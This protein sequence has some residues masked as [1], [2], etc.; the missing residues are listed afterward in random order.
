LTPDE[1]QALYQE[2]DRAFQSGDL[3]AARTHLER[4]VAAVPDHAEGHHYLGFLLAHRFHRLFLDEGV[5]HLRRAVELG[6]TWHRLQNLGDA[7]LAAGV[8]DG[9]AACYRGALA[10]AGPNA[11]PPLSSF[12]LAQCHEL[13]GDLRQALTLYRRAFT[14]DDNPVRS[15]AVALASKRLEATMRSRGIYF[16][17]E[18]EQHLL[19]DDDDDYDE[20]DDGNVNGNGNGNDETALAGAIARCRAQLA[21]TPVVFA[22]SATAQL[23]A[24]D[25]CLKTG[26]LLSAYSGRSFLLGRFGARE[27]DGSGLDD[28]AAALI[29]VSYRW[30]R[31]RV[32]WYAAGK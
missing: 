21:A 12:G 4:L 22:T 16:F 3:Y 11:A 13:A 28:L 17:S 25:Q 10:A 23:D 32:R 14:F 20:D 19:D 15:H 2:A 24:I 9:A 27:L 29:D 7:L 26:R 5:S 30:D 1:A 6:A 31:L 18:E 8:V